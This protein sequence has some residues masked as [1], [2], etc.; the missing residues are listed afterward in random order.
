[1]SARL[2]RCALPCVLA[3]AASLMGQDVG[4]QGGAGQTSGAGQAGGEG[5]SRPPKPQ[6]QQQPDPGGAKVGGKAALIKKLQGG[7]EGEEKADGTEAGDAAAGVAPPSVAVHSFVSSRGFTDPR[8]L[9]PGE[10]GFAYIQVD[11]RNNSV[12]PATPLR[13]DYQPKQKVLF[14]GSQEIPQP[15]L[16]PTGKDRPVVS[17]FD[18]TFLIKVPISVDAGAK[19]GKY[20]L[21]S[22][23]V[24]TVIDT[25]TGLASPESRVPANFEVEVGAPMAKGVG[26]RPGKAEVKADDDVRRWTRVVTDPTLIGVSLAFDGPG[27]L[28]PGDQTA[29]LARLVIPANLSVPRS[30][31]RIL[32]KDPPAGVLVGEPDLAGVGGDQLRGEAT[33]RLPIRISPKAEDGE[34]TIQIQVLCAPVDAAGRPA[35]G[36]ADAGIALRVLRRTAASAAGSEPAEVPV[37]GMGDLQLGG[38]EREPQASWLLLGG[39]GVVLVG[40]L[41]WLLLRRR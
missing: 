24:L 26:A 27:S 38:G 2:V 14:L 35:P 8:R 22:A 5:Q 12:V 9:A 7:G 25:A 21:E 23:V 37:T 16:R 1:M 13:L 15:K 28:A 11:V 18:D 33:C 41:V 17:G 31:L 6:V 36:G 40:G 10:S 34:R 30:T 39:G 32:C 3:M 29:L 4:G 20:L 19:H